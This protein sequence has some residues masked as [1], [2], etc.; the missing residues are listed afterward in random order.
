MAEPTQKEA[1]GI[2]SDGTPKNGSSPTETPEE[3]R[4]GA[5]RT[6]VV[7]GSLAYVGALAIPASRFATAPLGEGGGAGKAR[8]VRV[9]RLEDLPQGEPRRLQVIGDERD[10]FTLAK[11][12]RLGSVWVVREGDKVR[13]MSAI[14]PHLGCALDLGDDKKSF[15]CPC[16]ASRFALSGATEAGPSPRG[17]DAL[18]ARVQGGWIEIDFRR[19]RQGATDRREVSA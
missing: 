11:D 3:P 15:S 1:D 7:L 4:R 19:F 9:G 16:H 14:C 5:L 17:M 13:A 18:E 6:I 2:R 12:Q 8:W 10:A